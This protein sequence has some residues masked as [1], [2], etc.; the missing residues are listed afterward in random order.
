MMAFLM[1]A[2]G[3]TCGTPSEPFAADSLQKQQRAARAT[4]AQ[5]ESGVI[6]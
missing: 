6:R 3:S 2:A 4:K 1:I 5:S